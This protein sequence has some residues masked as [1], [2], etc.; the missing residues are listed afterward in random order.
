MTDVNFFKQTI[1][2]DG[3]YKMSN[4]SEFF[5]LFVKDSKVLHIGYADYPITDRQSN[6]HVQLSTYCN[7][8]DGFDINASDSIK[9][10]L[11]VKNGKFYDKW[12]NLPNNYDVI[13]VPEV[14]EHVDNVRSFLEQVDNLSGNLIISAPDATKIKKSNSYLDDAGIF[15]E[16]VH[17]DHN[18]WYSPY[19]LKN[20]IEKYSKTQKVVNMYQLNNSIVAICKKII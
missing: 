15:H 16:T 6:L 14:L 7:L 5:Q 18:C 11:S 2:I 9:S 3:T 13:L 4:R 8:I 17:P 19:T 20:V 12:S 1:R 10:Q